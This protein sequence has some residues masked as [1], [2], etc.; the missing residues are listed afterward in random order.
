MTNMQDWG[1]LLIKKNGGDGVTEQ[2][3]INKVL[4]LARSEIG[5]H[6]KASNAML[7]DKTANSGSA[8]YTKY[9]RD[10]DKV[11][12]F[13]NGAKNG[14]AWCDVFYDWLI[15]KCFG[16]D[17]AH[18]LLC[19]PVLS[20][21]AGCIYSAEYYRTHNRM[22]SSPAA[23]DQIFFTYQY[24]EV[25]HTG[26]VESVNGTTITTIEGN[27]SDGVYRRQYSSRSSQIYGYG[28]P[29]WSLLKDEAAP[30]QEEDKTVS[31]YSITLPTARNGDTGNFVKKI[32]VLLIAEGHYCGGRI[33]N[34]REIPDGEFGAST[35]NAVKIYQMG[36][37]LTKD[38]IVGKET[39]QKLLG[40]TV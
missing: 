10:L 31:G 17:R 21:G 4:A 6:E 22:F 36:N 3:A 24:G 33:V 40:V 19:Q 25:S 38:G 1:M 13:Y 8:N 16:A 15:Y 18:E 37:H 32:Q 20:L 26:I 28:R 30:V 27:T 35:E 23:G 12:A 9:A 14:Y 7:D 2:Q 11:T 34:K 29:D 39:M 5:Y